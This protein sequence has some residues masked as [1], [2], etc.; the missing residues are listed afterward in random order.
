M[1]SKDSSTTVGLAAL[2][3]LV[4]EDRAKSTPPPPGSPA[5]KTVNERPFGGLSYSGCG[6]AI[7]PA[8]RAIEWQQTADFESIAGASGTILPVD[9]KPDPNA[10]CGARTTPI[11]CGV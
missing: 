3:R 6:A 2:L 10:V 7:P 5:A 1:D 9:R 4:A 11:P 8:P